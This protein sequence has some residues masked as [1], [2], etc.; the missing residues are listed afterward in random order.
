MALLSTYFSTNRSIALGIAATGSSTGG[1]VYPAIVRALQPK[2]GFAWTVRVCG[3]LMAVVG[4]IAGSFL[5]P[6]LPPRKAGPLVEFAA[7]K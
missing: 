1:L 3:L 7:L 6:R 5:R 4:L 2:I